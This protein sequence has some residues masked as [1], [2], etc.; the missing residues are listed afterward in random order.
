[1]LVREELARRLPET[2]DSVITEVAPA[3]RFS[4]VGLA[5]IT[6]AALT[7]TGMVSVVCLSLTVICAVPV[8]L[9]V[10]LIFLFTS[11]AVAIF[12]LLLVT[13]SEPDSLLNRTTA[14]VF[15]CSV[16][17]PGEAVMTAELLLVDS[18]CS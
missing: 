1:M 13:F 16:N 4:E 3:A 6:G 14:V 9:A 8:A 12:E 18:D 7:V 11:L 17:E 5:L 2:L 10:T 15:F